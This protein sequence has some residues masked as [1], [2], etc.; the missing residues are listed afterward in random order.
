VNQR[1]R[2]LFLCHT[3]PYPPDGGV[4]I[5]TYNILRQLATAFDITLL[6]FERS[7]QATDVPVTDRSENVAA[8]S[9]F[10]QTTVFP[11]PQRRST[12]RYAWDHG[13]SLARRRVYTA[14]LYESAAF[15]R[16]LM[17]LLVTQRFDLVHVDSLDLCGY[18]PLLQHLPV[19]CTHHN[20]ESVLLRRRASAERHPLRR[21]YIAYQANLTARVER[22]WCERVALNVVVSEVDESVLRRLSPGARF[23]VVPNGVDLEYFQ[24]SNGATDGLV[25]VGAG[26]WFPNRDGL[27]YFCNEILPLV[28]RERPVAV[29]WAGWVSDGDRAEFIARHG[30]ELLGH[31]PDIRPHVLAARC[32]VVPLRVGG[33]S[34]L[35]ILDAWAMGKAVVTTSVGCEG[36]AAVHGENALIAD[37]PEAFAAA[38][39]QI[40]MDESLAL[41]LGAAARATVEREYGWVSLGLQL[42]DG[43][44]QLLSSRA[45]AG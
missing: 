3:L 20:A 10:A 39:R 17:E 44:R 12:L 18:L 16:R 4:W 5:R 38:V 21:A 37:G 33:G 29:R 27:Q 15:R 23:A 13:R 2:L 7:F 11:I 8:L 9:Q 40:L 30:L 24:P 31:V 26:S 45:P 22:Y 14:Y 1:P 41:R 42:I 34:R 35:K 32:Y 6:C 36:L 28:R 25:F 43:Y 19:S